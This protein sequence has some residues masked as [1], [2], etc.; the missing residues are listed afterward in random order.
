[1]VMF[2]VA[3]LVERPS[4]N[5]ILHERQIALKDVGSNL[6]LVNFSRFFFLLSD[7]KANKYSYVTMEFIRQSYFVF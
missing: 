7:F 1:M 5:A 3:Q 4:F 6:A 2:K